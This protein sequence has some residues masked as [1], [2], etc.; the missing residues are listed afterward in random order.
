MTARDAANYLLYLTADTFEDISNMKLNKLLYFGQGYYLQE[1]GKPMFDDEFEAWPHGP[2]VPTV[3]YQYNE[4]GRNPITEYDQDAARLVPDD[5]ADILMS[6]AQKYGRY[7]A[8]T[9]RGMT[10]A[11]GTPWAQV[12]RDGERDIQIPVSIMRDYFE[13]APPLTNVEIQFSEDDFIGYRDKD[14]YLVLPKDWDD[15]AV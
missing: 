4:Y 10:H 6:V 5:V 8:A 14:G 15:E 1:Y 2:V 13:N 3:Y 11:P 9:L 12:Y 7:N